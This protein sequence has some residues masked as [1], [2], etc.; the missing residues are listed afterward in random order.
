M[1]LDNTFY[2]STLAQTSPGYYVISN[3]P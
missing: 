2:T 1:G 3:C